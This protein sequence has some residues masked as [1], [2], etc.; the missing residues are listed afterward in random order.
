MHDANVDKILGDK[1]RKRSEPITT[2]WRVAMSWNDSL[3][4]NYFFCDTISNS[5]YEF[6]VVKVL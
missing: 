3:I 5:V 6:A 4:E 2:I 1:K